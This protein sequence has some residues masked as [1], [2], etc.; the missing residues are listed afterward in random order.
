MGACVYMCTSNLA[1]ALCDLRFVY[2]RTY[3][4]VY[5]WAYGHVYMLVRLSGESICVRMRP[6]SV[7]V[8]CICLCAKGLCKYEFCMSVCC[9]FSSVLCAYALY[10]LFWNEYCMFRGMYRGV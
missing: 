7:R 8:S 5:M 6:Y 2:L 1:H 4:W 9:L 3:V 10:V